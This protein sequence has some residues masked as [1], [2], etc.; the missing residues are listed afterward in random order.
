M[1][2]LRLIAVLCAIA[3]PGE[4]VKFLRANAGGGM[5][6]RPE[7]RQLPLPV[8]VTIVHQSSS[9]RSAT[10]SAWANGPK[11][12]HWPGKRALVSRPIRA[13]E[14]NRSVHGS[15]IRSTSLD[16]LRLTE[17]RANRKPDNRGP[18]ATIDIGKSM[19]VNS[20]ST[21]PH[22]YGFALAAVMLTGGCATDSNSF[23]SG[24]SVTVSDPTRQTNSGFLSDYSRLA[25]VSWKGGEGIQCWRDTDVDVNKYDKVMIPR[26]TVTLKPGQQ[27]GIDP[28]DLKMLTDYFHDAMATSL[29]PQIAVVDEAG[30]GVLAVRVALTDLVPTSVSKSVTGSLVPYGFVAE[31]GAG[32]ATGRPAGSTP[33]LG[34][35]GMEMQ[36][37]DGASE[38]IV[39]ECRDTEVGRKYAAEL[40][41]G[42]V[43]AA[44]TWANGYVN[45]FQSWSYAKNALDKWAALTAMRLAALREAAPAR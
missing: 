38:K 36:F 26:M 19:I 3:R 39:A 25:T 31:A 5:M 41:S 30:P 29:K 9:Q 2:K 21:R 12:S 22:I 15:R 32:A 4:A 17:A 6:A 11:N 23:G 13:G 8:G 45:S 18:L 1:A 24:E 34:E 7:R 37:I 28:T 43:G 16:D 27:Q 40:D 35:T 42:A 20:Y 14:S 33:Y 10:T 44:Q